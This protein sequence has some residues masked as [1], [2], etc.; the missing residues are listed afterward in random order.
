[1]Y[2]KEINLQSPMRILETSIHG[3]LGR[4]NLGVVMSRAGVGKTAALVQIGLDDLMRERRVLHI[5]L[6]EDQLDHVRAWYE[7]LFDDMARVCEL[8]EKETVRRQIASRRIIQAHTNTVLTAEQLVHTLQLFGTHLDFRPDALL[9]DGFD[10]EAD[11]AQ[12]GASLVALKAA[13]RELDAELWMTAQTHREVTGAHPTEVPAPCAAWVG[14]IDVALR[15]EPHDNHVQIRLLKDHDHEPVAETHLALQPDTMRLVVVGGGKSHVTPPRESCT[16]LSGAATGSEEVFGACAE[17]WGLH[18]INYTFKGRKAPARTRGLTL[19]SDDELGRGAVS[20][21]YVEAHLHRKFPST[22]TFQRLL[23]SIWH[24]VNTAGQVFVVGK[25]LP[26]GT[27]KG[28]TGWAAELAKHLE[29][30]LH[31]FDQ[32]TEKWVTWQHGGWVPEPGPTINARRFTGTGT[33]F[34]SETGRAAVEALFER[35]FGPRAS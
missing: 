5:A 35:S 2:R 11:E 23:R 19:L 3:G 17:R 12:V 1:M 20:E 6:G 4:G 27:V 24:Q 21:R 9:V 30:S 10:W 13:A 14:K 32:D 7:A 8:E 28:G 26:D 15:L 16:L 22:P 34:L 18:E 31:V 25:V 33:R 29:K